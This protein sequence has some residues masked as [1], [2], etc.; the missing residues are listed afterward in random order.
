MIMQLLLDWDLGDLVWT[1]NCVANDL[2]DFENVISSLLGS[3]FPIF[4]VLSSAG[5]VSHLHELDINCCSACM[6]AL[7]P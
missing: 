7:A 5:W 4:A 6:S 3:P 2:H 1:L